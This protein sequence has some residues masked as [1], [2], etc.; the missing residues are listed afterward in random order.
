MAQGYSAFYEGDTTTTGRSAVWSALSDADK[1]KFIQDPLNNIYS[2][3]GELIQVR[4]R[5]RVIRG[6][7]GSWEDTLINERSLHSF[8]AGA[9]GLRFSN[10]NTF[11]KIQGKLTSAPAPSLGGDLQDIYL[12][13]K[14]TG[15]T[16]QPSYGS[17]STR[18]IN[19]SEAHN[20]ELRVIPICLVSRLNQGGYHPVHNPSGTAR[21]FKTDGSSTLALWSTT[22]VKT[23]SN[24][25]QCFDF[26]NNISPVAGEVSPYVISNTGAIGQAADGRGDGGRYDSI[27][28]GQ[29]RDLR[30][31]A[32]GMHTPVSAHHTLSKR[33]R[34]GEARGWEK[35]PRI[36]STISGGTTISTSS[37]FVA[38][39]P[40]TEITNTS[41]FVGGTVIASGWMLVGGVKHKITSVSQDAT[42]AYIKCYTLD[43]TDGANAGQ[44]VEAVF[45]DYIDAP[46]SEGLFQNITGTPSEIAATFPNGVMGEWIP[47]I[48]DG[49]TKE[50]KST[51]KNL[52]QYQALLTTDSGATWGNSGVSSENTDNSFN[53]NQGPAGV[54][55]IPF[56][57]KANF[58]EETAAELIGLLYGDMV[59]THSAYNST[60]NTLG[61]GWLLAQSLA[62]TIMTS[63][64]LSNGTIPFDTFFDMSSIRTQSGRASTTAKTAGSVIGSAETSDGIQWETRVTAQD[65]L[66]SLVIPYRQIKHDGTSYGAG[67]TFNYVDNTSN[68]LDDNGELIQVGTARSL[69]D[70]NIIIKEN[71]NV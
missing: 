19:T 7:E 6:L 1:A 4:A 69:D 25:S 5:A 53:T 43:P 67:L 32:S 66:A 62:N 31:D 3:N 21:F 36:L 15:A 16:N 61:S 17:C 30:I 46:Y 10:N 13:Y 2:D 56:R 28:A 20:A 47:V 55:I 50:Y 26:A 24:K 49:T 64:Y 8:V 34:N 59:A 9:G 42:A 35:Q 57:A 14:N 48:P 51:K 18:S 39:V 27:T 60:S 23:I 68:A 54:R 52:E 33:A 58:T 40:L 37:D 22:G 11:V 38:K 29:I 71:F 63:G 44:A 41:W 45:G 12:D 70:M 65:G